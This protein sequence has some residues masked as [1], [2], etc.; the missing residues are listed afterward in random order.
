MSGGR[1]KP[2]GGHLDKLTSTK[3]LQKKLKK[4]LDK[5][6]KVCY[7]KYVKRTRKSPKHQ[8]GTHYEEEHHDH[9]RRLYQERS[10]T[11]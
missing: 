4:V 11:G 6:K 10:R 7:N 9:Y 1:K 3:K 5:L 8:K 2:T